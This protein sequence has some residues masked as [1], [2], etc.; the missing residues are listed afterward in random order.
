MELANND[1]IKAEITS[2]LSVGERI[3]T[4]GAYQIKL[5]AMSGDLPIHGHT[6]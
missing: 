5:A 2:G 1:G 6:H 4:Q 3:V